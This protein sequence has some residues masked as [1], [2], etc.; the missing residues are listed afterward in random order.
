MTK[1]TGV[2]RGGRRAG[3]G[4][5]KGAQTK[6]TR[7]V[8]LQAQAE[9]VTPLEVNLRT[10]RAIWAKANEGK[11]LDI[12]L[13]KEACEI[14]KDAMPFMHARIS[15]IPYNPD[16]G[17]KDPGDRR[18]SELEYARRIAYLLHVGALHLPRQ[19]VTIE[20]ST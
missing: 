7:A 8:A 4:R 3:A 19:P 18:L 20:A 6:R 9:G 11:E 2:G 16:E 13:A 15:P 5:R 14:G 12:A 17:I 1:P 10:M